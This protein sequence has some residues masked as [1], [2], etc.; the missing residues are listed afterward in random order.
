MNINNNTSIIKTVDVYNEVS[1]KDGVFSFENKTLE[2]VI[3]V[4][5][6]WYNIEIVFKNNSI[7]NEEFIGILRK[8]KSL[9]V[10]LESIKNYGIIKNFEI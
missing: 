3:K 10:I 7:K 6:R 2:E 4:L 1:W 9:K 5:S 8:N